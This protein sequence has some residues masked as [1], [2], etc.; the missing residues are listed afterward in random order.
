MKAIMNV[1][2]SAVVF[3]FSCLCCNAAEVDSTK[4]EFAEEVLYDT[5]ADFMRARSSV[6]DVKKYN[7]RGVE[8]DFAKYAY[9][10]AELSNAY[11][12]CDM[13]GVTYYEHENVRE[14]GRLLTVYLL[15]DVESANDLSNA[16]IKKMFSI[17]K[18]PAAELAASRA[19]RKMFIEA[20]SIHEGI[21]TIRD[22]LVAKYGEAGLKKRLDDIVRLHRAIASFVLKD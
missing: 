10:Y 3:T 6:R 12:I 11:E 18:G 19:G 4:R 8:R 1:V 13:C 2:V 20:D 15:M 7:M 9:K 22:E 21:K 16:D 5:M 14:Y 17:L